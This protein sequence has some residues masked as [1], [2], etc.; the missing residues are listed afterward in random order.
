MLTRSIILISCCALLACSPASETAPTEA[1]NTP[2]AAAST[3]PASRTASFSVEALQNSLREI[4]A[5]D[6][7]SLD[8]NTRRFEYARV[9]LNG[10]GRKETFVRF[11]NPTFCGSGGCSYLLLDAD[12]QLRQRFTQIDPDGGLVVMTAQQHGWRDLVVVHSSG[13]N[14]GPRRLMFDGQQYPANASMAPEHQPSMEE[15]EDPDIVYLFSQAGEGIASG[16]L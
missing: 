4:L 7:A 9:D 16:T 12:L 13:G 6:L 8:A 11:V 10:D 1:Q 2:A 3:P 15:D 14:S 5:A